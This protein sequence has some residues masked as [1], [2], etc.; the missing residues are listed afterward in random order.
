MGPYAFTHQATS[1]A[2]SLRLQMHSTQHLDGT[3]VTVQPY[4][5]ALAHCD[6]YIPTDP[7][8]LA[9]AINEEEPSEVMGYDFPDLRARLHAQEGHERASSIWRAACNIHDTLHCE[10]NL[11]E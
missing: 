4:R 2:S 8:Q 9:G 7:F 5:P 10:T 1:V 3:T 6:P 11:P